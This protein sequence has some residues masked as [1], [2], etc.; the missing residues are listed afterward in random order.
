VIW[1]LFAPLSDLNDCITD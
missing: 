1:S